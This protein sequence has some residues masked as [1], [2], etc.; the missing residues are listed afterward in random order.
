MDSKPANLEQPATIVNPGFLQDI[1]MSTPDLYLPLATPSSLVSTLTHM[2]FSHLYNA[3]LLSH[4]QT[5]LQQVATLNVN[6]QVILSACAL[7]A[8]YVHCSLPVCR[9]I[10]DLPVSKVDRV[11]GSSRMLMGSLTSTANDIR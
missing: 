6:L 2:F 4:K 3:P 5:L 1:L 11:I 7:A 9:V 8:K 10:R